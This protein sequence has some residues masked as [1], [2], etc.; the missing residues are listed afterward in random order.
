MNFKKS[1]IVHVTEKRLN[2]LPFK[3]DP[4][5]EPILL[6]EFRCSFAGGSSRF[7]K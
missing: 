7:G 2:V 4:Y 6:R 1:H 5:P 3:A